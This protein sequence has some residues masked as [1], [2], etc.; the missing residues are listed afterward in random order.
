MIVTFG[1]D[2]CSP[3]NFVAHVPDDYVVHVDIGFVFLV[4]LP[5]MH[6]VGNRGDS[7]DYVQVLQMGAD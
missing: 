6:G 4:D 5:L 1:S 3:L 7:P 2:R